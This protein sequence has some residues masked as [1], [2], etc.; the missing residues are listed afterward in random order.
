LWHPT[1]A[2]PTAFVI[3]P[4]VGEAEN[5]NEKI[6]PTSVLASAIFSSF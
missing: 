3:L 2:I 5:D 6:A 4:I 1:I